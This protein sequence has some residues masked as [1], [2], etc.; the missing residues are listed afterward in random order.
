MD[1]CRLVDG[2]PLAI[3][4]AAAQVRTFSCTEIARRLRED[5]LGALG[6]GPRTAADRQRTMESVID[7]GYRLLSRTEQELLG[8]LAVFNGGFTLEAAS[9]VCS[10]NGIDSGEIPALVAAL[11]DRSLVNRTI[12]STASRY[13]LLETI[14]EYAWKRLTAGDAQQTW[15][16]R[17]VGDTWEVGPESATAHVRDSKGLRHIATLVATPG[18]DHHAL[19]LQG[20]PLDLD[21]AAVEVLDE[22][23]RDSYRSRIKELEE[24]LEDAEAMSDLARAERART[25][26]DAVLA[27]L[28][29]ATGLGGRPRTS[30]ANAERARAAVTKAIRSSI[31]ALQGVSPE[32]ALH[33]GE[34]IKTGTHCR[35]DGNARWLV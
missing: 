24:E 16:L 28:R 12:R 10:G 17:R 18:R 21:S 4:L 20:S 30:P 14:R 11:V 22:T 7:W 34:H 23:A 5:R 26:L 15:V 9:D 6:S 33:L 2:L 32:T 13:G 27:E 19:E 1:I 25:E 31:S 3:E 35:Y 8:R 29:R